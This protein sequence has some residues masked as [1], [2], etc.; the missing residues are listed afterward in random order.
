MRESAGSCGHSGPVTKEGHD[1]SSGG[2]RT[3]PRW[4]W[5]AAAVLSAGLLSLALET[6]SHGVIHFPS[7]WKDTAQF[8]DAFWPEFAATFRG[9]AAAFLADRWLSDWR[10]RQAEQRGQRRLEEVLKQ[11]EA[12]LEN[13][14][15]H[16]YDLAATPE[17]RV[18]FSSG[19]DRATWEMTR[20]VVRNPHGHRVGGRPSVV[21][22]CIGGA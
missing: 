18:V 20:D 4:W 3:T 22:R 11:L 6:W 14:R 1:H 7:T 12:A 21:P 16:C 9:V 19:F 2:S 17:D 8:L 15:W 5:I 13:N 10:D